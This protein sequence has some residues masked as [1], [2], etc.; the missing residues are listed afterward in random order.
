MILRCS[1]FHKNLSAFLDHELDSREHKQMEQHISECM[2]CRQEAEKLQE[3]I[4][5]VRATPRPETPA[6]AWAGTLQ[7][8][9]TASEKPSR[10]WV[11]RMQKWGTIP[12]AAAVFVLL[13]YILSSQMFLHENGTGPMSL[14]DYVQEHEISSAQ[15]VLS[16]DF[17]SELTTVQTAETTETVE[18]DEPMSELDMLV[19]VHYGIYSTNGS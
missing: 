2:D 11:F 13:L 4:G 17:L 7:K 19:E 6:Q 1:S 9:E 16:P 5:S 10:A 14:A 8:I 12:A 15:Q 18:S 3:I